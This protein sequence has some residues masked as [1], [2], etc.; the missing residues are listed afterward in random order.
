MGIKE[1]LDSVRKATA[2]AALKSGRHPEEIVLVGVSK[3]FSSSLVRQALDCGLRD[4][5]ENRLHEA[6]EKFPLFPGARKHFIGHLQSNKTKRVVELCD[7]IQSVDSMKIAQSISDAA[8]ANGRIMP[9]LVQVLT[10]QKKEFGI[11]PKGLEKFLTEA[12][13]M[14]GMRIQ[15]MMTIGPVFKTREESRQFFR[16]MKNLHVSIAALNIPKVE[17]RYLSMGMSSDFTTAI[18]EGANMVRVGTA[19]FGQRNNSPF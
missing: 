17:M 15:G 4:I 5:A 2:E 9:V 3:T 10:D 12:S 14:E 13:K 19:L 8:I 18:E 6:E 7:M 11:R 16:R 1:N